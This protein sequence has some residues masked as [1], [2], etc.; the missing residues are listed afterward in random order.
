VAIPTGANDV[1]EPSG[2]LG[3]AE[4]LGRVSELAVDVE[5][6]SMHHFHARLCFVQLGTDTDI[7]LVDTLAEGVRLDS[8]QAAFLSPQVTKFFHAS[9]GDLTYLAEANVRVRGLFDTH[10]AA[11]L[12]GWPKVGLADLVLEHCGQVLKKEHQQADFSLRPLP[13]ELRDYIA[14]DVRYL[15]DVGRI[16]REACVKADILDEVLIDCER[17][18]DDATVRPDPVANFSPKLPRSEVKGDKLPLAWHIAQSLNRLRHGWA[19]AEDLPVGRML[20]NM[21]VVAICTGLPETERELAKQAGV[22]GAFVRAHGAEVLAVVKEHRAQLAAG[23]LPAMPERTRENDPKKKK[24]EE[25]LMNFRKLKSTERKVT[26]SVVLPNL[27][28][29]D[30]SQSYPRSLDELARVPYLGPKRLALYGQQVLEV[31]AGATK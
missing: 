23:T 5:A 29:E 30:L 11:T 17:L 20:S 25:A 1:T 28:V 4:A 2:L 3:V 7:F 9:Q 18:C 13:G 21:A 22:R 10:R 14:D 31:L 8:L 24:R 16:V 26:P 15:V 27:L 19:E 6:D 12:L